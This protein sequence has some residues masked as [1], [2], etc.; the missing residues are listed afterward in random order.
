VWSTVRPF[1]RILKIGF[2]GIVIQD[3]DIDS[4]GI[5]P[6]E[7]I[8]HRRAFTLMT[9]HIYILVVVVVMATVVVQS[10]VSHLE[11]ERFFFIA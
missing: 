5:S 11:V 8:P 9:W 3:T 10:I 7:S 6:E 4:H 2:I 1:F